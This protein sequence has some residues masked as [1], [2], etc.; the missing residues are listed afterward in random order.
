MI[1]ENID[2]TSLNSKIIEGILSLIPKASRALKENNLSMFIDITNTIQTCSDHTFLSLKEEIKNLIFEVSW[3][4]AMSENNL[5]EI[6]RLAEKWEINMISSCK[7][8]LI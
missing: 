6:T 5:S 2:I 7:R 4:S 1:L 3:D 8:H